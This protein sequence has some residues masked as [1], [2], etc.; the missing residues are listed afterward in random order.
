MDAVTSAA[1]NN[2]LSQRILQD[3][4]MRGLGQHT[5]RDK[6]HHVYK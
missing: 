2:S 6:I 1:P 3:M 5:Q 4:K